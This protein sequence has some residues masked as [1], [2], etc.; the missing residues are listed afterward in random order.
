MIALKGV[1]TAKTPF[2]VYGGES[3][4]SDADIIRN[5]NGEVFIPG[6]SLAG[7]CRDYLEK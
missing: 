2:M 5:K 6:T 4:D 3:E 7:V 1:L